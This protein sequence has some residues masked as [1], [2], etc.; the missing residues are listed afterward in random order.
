MIP[1]QPRP[2]VDIKPADD[3]TPKE[4]LLSLGGGGSV[5]DLATIIGS[6]DK[7]IEVVAAAQFKEVL[8]PD[9]D[10]R[11]STFLEES[12]RRRILSVLDVDYAVIIGDLKKVTLKEKGGMGFYMGFFGAGYE[13]REA[14]LDATIIDMRTGR[15]KRKLAAEAHGTSGGIGLFY[16]LILISDEEGSVERGLGKKVAETLS[17][18]SRKDNIR[19]LIFGMVP[20]MDRSQR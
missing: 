18:L 2:D 9:R 13:E 3:S 17:A 10:Q 6:M 11:L 8:F 19:I 12:N 14:R 5:E 16:G 7:K 20:T 1:Y 15:L 4:V